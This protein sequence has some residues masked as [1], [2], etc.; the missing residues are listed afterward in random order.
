LIFQ[1]GGNIG[2]NL[3]ATS[4]KLLIKLSLA[5]IKA[6]QSVATLNYDSAVSM[7]SYQR[8]VIEL[9]FNVSSFKISN[10]SDPCINEF[11]EIYLIKSPEYYNL[12]LAQSF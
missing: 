8:T 4:I 11:L 12:L 9:S 1:S 7:T 2:L 10:N 6:S 3:S 5:S